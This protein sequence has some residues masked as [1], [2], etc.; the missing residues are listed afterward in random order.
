MDNNKDIIKSGVSTGKKMIWIGILFFVL[1]IFAGI[2]RGGIHIPFLLVAII[3]LIYGYKRVD[4]AKK[5]YAYGYLMPL[6][7]A[8]FPNS[9][10]EISEKSDAPALK[11][12]EYRIFEDDH[13]R[14]ITN[15]LVANDDSDFEMFT[16]RTS[17]E[18]TDSD[19]DT[20]TSTSFHGTVLSYKLDTGLND[21]VR[22]L[23]SNNKK[24]LFVKH[25]STYANKKCSLTPVK[26]ETGNIEFDDNYEVYA[27]QMHDAYY[28]LNPYVMEKL[29]ALREK[30]GRYCMALTE[31]YVN[32][33][34][35]KPDLIIELPSLTNNIDENPL[36][37]AKQQLEDLKA[38]LNDI[39]FALSKH[40]AE[41]KKY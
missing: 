8:T 23:C 17:H 33:S 14:D 28:L 38:S 36:V 21:I 30:Y 3:V 27:G 4:E 7:S 5:E 31:D 39:A 16:L 26:I 34:F 35:E 22:I 6:I 12:T 24:I 15:H 2:F 37:H 9:T 41:E 32:I 18:Y 13:D 25:E 10:F 11:Y 29:Q 40:T 1:S 19:G 20:H